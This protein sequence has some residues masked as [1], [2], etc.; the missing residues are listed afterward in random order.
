MAPV[1]LPLP[2]GTTATDRNSDVL[3]LLLNEAL[4]LSGEHNRQAAVHHDRST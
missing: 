1:Y 2:P 4:C 3:S